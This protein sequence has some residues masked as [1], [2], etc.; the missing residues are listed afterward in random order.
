MYSRPL[1]WSLP[2]DPKPLDQYSSLHLASQLIN[3]LIFDFDGLILDTEP[4]TY[5]SW[6]EVYAANGVPLPFEHWVKTPGSKNQELQPQHHLCVRLVRPL[7]HG[8][9]GRRIRWR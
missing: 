9:V 2:R 8:M 5:Q 1:E 4:P 3:A 7:T 6:A